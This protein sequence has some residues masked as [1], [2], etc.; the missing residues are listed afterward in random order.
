MNILCLDLE[1]CWIPEIWINVAKQTG[2]EE[3]KI[4]TRDEPDYDKLMRQ[5]IQILKENNLKLK[6]IQDII[7]KMPLLEGAKETLDSLRSVVQTIIVSDTFEEFSKPFMEKLDWPVIF[8]NY[9]VVD[10]Q[11]NIVD[12]KLRQEDQKG[13]VVKALKSLNYNIIASGD[14]YNDI[15]MLD[16]ADYGILFC[17]PENVV[18]DYPNFP[19]ANNYKELKEL[20]FKIINS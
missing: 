2:I 7:A 4:T 3:L 11:N 16:G 17:P 5:R 6:D 12:Y 18:K 15:T 20:V 8:C 13:K 19:V 10:E 14:S 1:G 9:L